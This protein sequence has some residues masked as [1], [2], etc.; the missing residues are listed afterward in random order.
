MTIG[1]LIL[2]LILAPLAALTGFAGLTL[3]ERLQAY[4]ESDLLAESQVAI[5]R[6]DEIV[7]A[8][9]VE[10]GRSAQFLGG[11]GATPPPALTESRAGADRGV[12]HLRELSDAPAIIATGLDVELR[13]VLEALEPLAAFRRDVDSRKISAQETTARYTQIVNRLLETGFKLTGRI[14]HSQLINNA[15]A[16]NFLAA[17]AENMGQQ[18]AAGAAA[19]ARGGLDVRDAMR[20]DALGDRERDDT[21]RFALFAEADIAE[22]LKNALAAPD[23]RRAIDL[24]A[25]MLAAS[26]GQPPG[27]DGADW[28]NSATQRLDVYAGAQRALLRALGETARANTSSALA[29]ALA[30]GMAILAVAGLELGLA[31][32][33]VR[34]LSRPVS[35]MAT[36]LRRLAEGDMEVETPSTRGAAEIGEMARA[37]IAFRET[38]A[39]NARLEAAA[40]QDRARLDSEREANERERKTAEAERAAAMEEVA[41]ALEELSRNRL[42]HRIVADL[43]VA[44]EAVKTHFNAAMEE[45]ETT[46]SA[47]RETASVVREQASQIAAASDELAQRAQRQATK[48]DDSSEAIRALSSVV[49]RTAKSSNSTKD[50]IT[51][52]KSHALQNLIV[53]RDTQTAIEQIRDSSQRI[54]SI[55]GAIDEIAFQT[56]LLAL[57]AGVEAARAGETGK[58]FAVVAAEVRGLALRSAEAAKEIKQLVE[59]SAT[60]VSRGV[61]LVAAAGRAFHGIEQQISDIDS[62]VADIAGQTLDQSVKIKQINTALAEMDGD[63]QQNAAMA[64]QATAACRAMSEESRRLHELIARFT[65]RSDEHA[66]EICRAA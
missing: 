45:V 50:G 29:Q 26:P 59:H 17:A 58:G 51:A 33:I 66:H 28:F 5:S 35:R 47:V 63:T 19:I 25:R 8:A 30:A 52:A 53:V 1:R 6:L 11:S 64:E 13:G 57:N 40:G 49:E 65:L 3:F 20:L 54:G 10:R 24:R 38:V 46:L 43:P 44:Y 41:A 32:W 48:L 12:A 2:V 42:S 34:S 7:T 9:Q 39:A 21:A 22:A 55:I 62:S 60:E 15:L 56:N 4:R 36:A 31:V 61:D 37:L 18:R 14:T 27:V 23:G 16:L